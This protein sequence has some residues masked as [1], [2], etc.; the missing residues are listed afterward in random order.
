MDGF[1]TSTPVTDFLFGLAFGVV[2]ALIALSLVLI[3]RSSHVLNFG[4]GAIAMFATYVG[5]VELAQNLHVEY[6]LSVLA[7]IAAGIAL[8]ALSEFVLIRRL[9]GKP[10]LNPIVVMVGVYLLLTYFAAGIWGS[11][12]ITLPQKFSPNSW[13]LHGMNVGISPFAAAEI[14][15]AVV[16]AVA[17]GALFRFTKL[18]L[19][20]RAAA[21]APEV[22][23]LLGVRTS[24]MRT[25][26]WGLSAGI[27]AVAGILFS[28]QSSGVFPG[29][30]DGVFVYGFI[31]AAIGG[32]ESPVGALTAGMALGLLQA[33][34]L[35]YINTNYVT[36]SGLLL[37]LAV[38]M[39]RPSGLFGHST[40]RV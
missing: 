21:L 20:L 17:T 14:V 26:G 30:M 12:P 32:L 10:E 31:A 22:A 2:I 16:V 27:G 9:Y 15:A 40:R 13:Q 4:Q 35:S 8:G 34:V 24:R 29:N 38:L 33:Y 39:V 18:G 36:V 3:W 6:W 23:T 25:I 5:M 37:L 1:L 7:S 11:N 19:Q 28:S